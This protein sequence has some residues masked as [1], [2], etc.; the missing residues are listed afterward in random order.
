MI[1]DL[2][3]NNLVTGFTALA[4]AGVTDAIIR[5][6]M[7]VGEADKC[8]EKYATLAQNVG[9][10]VSFYHLA[11]PDAKNGG[12]LIDDATAEADYFVRLVQGLSPIK[13]LAIDLETPTKLSR[14][15]YELWVITWLQRVESLTGIRPMIYSNKFFLD[16]HLPEGHRLG[17]YNL[18]I[19]NYRNIPAPELP[20]GWDNYFL[21]QYTETGTVAGIS[22][23][24]DISKT[25]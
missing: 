14:E 18:W 8:L 16:M 20:N 2:S 10:T 24:V 23:K 9:I 25:A 12:N 17:A 21:W 3:S 4:A 15:D 11:Y 6:S 19:A 5:A 22:G 13:W 1:I 7:G